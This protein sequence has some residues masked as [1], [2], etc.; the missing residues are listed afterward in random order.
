M[1]AFLALFSSLAVLACS[2][3]GVPPMAPQKSPHFDTVSAEL[4]LGGTVYAYADIDGDPE[5]ATDFLLTLM[6]DV[7]GMMPK[8][9]SGLSASRLVRILGIQGVRAVGLSSYETD[10]GYHNRA[11]IHHTAEREGLL[12]VLGSEP[13]A[14]D[15][16]SIA[17]A[18]ADLVW[19]QQLD[20][21]AV[22]EIVR[23]VG[24]LGVGMSPEQ[25]DAALRERFLGLDISLRDVVERPDLEVGLVLA[26]DEGRVLRIP[27]MPFSFPYTDFLVRIDGLSAL[28][29]AIVKRASG[30]P[31]I[32]V[33]RTSD[34]IIVRPAIVLPPPWNAY[35]P[36]IVKEVASGRMYVV[37]SPA[38]L[39]ACLKSAGGVAEAPDYQRALEGLPSAGNAMVY[40]SPRLTRAAHGVLDGVIEA[41]GSSI[42]TSL[43][44]FFLPD[45]GTP[46]GWVASH[47]ENGLRITSNTPSSHKTTLLTLGY[48]ALLPG[49]AVIG[50][51]M[52]APEQPPRR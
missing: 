49:L 10:A 15:L 45:I 13:E 36:S 29:D 26:V 34:W 32:A 7:P 33:E 40:M 44:R 2:A 35:E 43:V 46:V 21:E 24:A 5:R 1:K 9:P 8:K 41:N 22:V 20:L 28:A 16:L 47:A 17:P 18:R 30:D 19:D 14:F 4:Q 52:L 37:S 25:L 39:Q 38:F 6:R 27:G 48:V 31:F 50:S 51:S 23:A 42:T 12:K 3:S 11:F